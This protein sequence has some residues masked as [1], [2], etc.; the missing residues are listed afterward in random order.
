MLAN[1][2]W[3]LRGSPQDSL[4]QLQVLL[5]LGP[6]AGEIS[7]ERSRGG[8]PP[9]WPCRPPA[10]SLHRGVHIPTRSWLAGAP[11]PALQGGSRRRSSWAPRDKSLQ[12]NWAVSS[13]WKNQMTIFFYPSLESVW[14]WQVAASANTL[15][16]LIPLGVETNC[17]HFP[18]LGKFHKG[19]AQSLLVL[20]SAPCGTDPP[21]LWVLGEH[22]VHIWSSSALN[23]TFPTAL[24][25][26]YRT[27]WLSVYGFRER[28]VWNPSAAS[29]WD[30]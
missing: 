18:S 17:S 20:P 2:L 30:F 22:L 24:P 23:L 16:C 4:W 3:H 6:R 21:G 8:E 5:V 9:P 19:R 1:P 7:R 12:A 11:P 13:R 10:C 15:L 25:P 14:L 29:Q 27:H 28:R 26:N